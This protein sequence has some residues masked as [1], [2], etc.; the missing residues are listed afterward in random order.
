M[1]TVIAHKPVVTEAVPGIHRVEVD[2]ETAGYV[3]EAGIVF[4]SLSGSV[5]NT[6]CEV[7]QSLD[8]DTAVHRVLTG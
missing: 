3:L 2:G 4:V 6:S 8:F 1:T 7:A 5:Y